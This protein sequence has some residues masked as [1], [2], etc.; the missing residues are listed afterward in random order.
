MQIT[1]TAVVDRSIASAAVLS[2]WGKIPR[3]QT[4]EVTFSEREMPPLRSVTR[5]FYSGG[6]LRQTEQFPDWVI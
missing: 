4:T 5:G 6:D 1:G 2:F 3:H